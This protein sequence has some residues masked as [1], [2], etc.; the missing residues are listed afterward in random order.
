[1]K[2]PLLILLATLLSI[3]CSMAQGFWLQL[4]NA[5]SGLGRFDDV[6]FLNENL[7][8]A[9]NGPS[10]QVYKTTDGGETWTLQFDPGGYFRNIEFLNE[11]IGFLGTLSNTFYKTTD[12]GDTWTEVSITPNPPAICGLDTVGESTVYGCG[13]WFDP[14]YVIKSTD[15]G[16]TWEFIDMSAYAEAL[17]EVLFIDEQTG[18]VSG[19]ASSGG[20]ILKTTDGGNSW[21]PIFNS[22]NEGDYVWKLQLLENNTVMFGSIQSNVSGRLAKSLDSGLNWQT[23]SAPEGFVQAVGFQ[24]PERGWMGGHNTGFYETNDGGETWSSL[25]LGDN[26]NRIFWLNPNL[27]YASGES[28]YKFTGFLSTEEFESVPVPDLDV[29]VA[30]TPIKD[31]LNVEIRFTHSD[32]LVIELYDLTGRFITKFIREQITD[33]NTKQYSFDFNYSPGT[34]LLDV[35]TNNHRKGI[36][37]T[38]E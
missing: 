33:P 16:E 23:F 32:N 37:I 28:I 31:K 4:S 18:F 34:Y 14:A 1:M 7:G 24:T 21:T 22:G 11:N 13:A 36:V 10:S 8:W 9:A 2:K 6:F 38:K 20:V 15:S 5:P 25:G 17:V 35:H 26:L 27:G 3:T 19:N 30:P 29:K 12:G